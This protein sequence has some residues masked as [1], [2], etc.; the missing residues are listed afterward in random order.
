M[1]EGRAYFLIRFINCSNFSGWRAVSSGYVDRFHH[2][3]GIDS[4][5]MKNSSVG[6]SDKREKAIELKRAILIAELKKLN[7]Y[8]TN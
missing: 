7:E 1:R 3:H 5:Q 4:L 2:M 8:Q 6:L